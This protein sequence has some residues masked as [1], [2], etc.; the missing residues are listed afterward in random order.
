MIDVLILGAGVAGLAAASALKTAGYRILVLE[1]RD[2]IGGRVYTHRD[3]RLPVPIELGAEFIHGEATRTRQLLREATQAAID[4]RGDPWSAEG[5]KLRPADQWERIERVLKRVDRRSKDLAFSEFLERRVGGKRLAADRRAAARFVQGFDAADLEQ[6]STKSVGPEGLESVLRV[7]RVVSGY[8]AVPHW[9]ARDLGEHIRL[10]NE[11]VEVRWQPG[12]VEVTAKAAS[13]R[14]DR[15]QARA[16]VLTFPIGVL[17]AARRTHDGLRI[18]PFPS[19]V[20]NALDRLA[21]GSVTRLV[22]WFHAFPWSSRFPQGADANRTGFVYLARGPF[23]VWWTAYPL[24]LPVA[25]AWCGGPPSYPHSGRPKT[26]VE[27]LA[28]SSLAAHLGIS[29]RGV[30]SRVRASWWHDWT[31]DPFARGAYSYT[32]VN[33]VGAPKELAK[34][35]ESTLFFSGEATEASGTVEAALASGDRVATQVKR[36]LDA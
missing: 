10:E 33:G 13:G 2:R 36:A 19:R 9:L 24:E 4:I 8:D 20:A 28:F 31:A 5:G 21:M 15:I 23:M 35:I 18:D 17:E 22:V 29:R 12:Q 7:G 27:G 3:A 6:V 14:L 30:T 34:P 32:R 1:A 25:V 26:E 11:V 16:A